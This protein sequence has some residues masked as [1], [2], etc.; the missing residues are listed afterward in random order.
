MSH[1]SVI[2]VALAATVFFA[3]STALKHRSASTL[4][5]P[6]GKHGTARLGHFLAM[7]VSHRWWLAAILADAIGLGLQAFA[8]HIGAVSVVQPVLVTALLFSLV[9]NHVAARTRITWRELGWGAFLAASVA[10]FLV[11]SGATTAGA[12]ASTADRGAAVAVAVLAV[13]LGTGSVVIA[14][15]LPSGGRAALLGVVVGTIYACTALLLK[16]VTAVAARGGLGAVLT[17]WQLPVLVLAGV[18]GMVLAQ[19]AFRSGPLNASLPAMATLDPLLSVALGVIVYDEQLRT[20]LWPTI[21]EILSLAAL[22]TGAVALSRLSADHDE[23]ASSS[24]EQPRPTGVTRGDSHGG[25][26]A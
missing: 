26:L 22:A 24:A 16:A 10:C 3:L 8:L 1:P 4:P 14:R 18:T 17:S 5:E 12:H 2:L 21:G 20:G 13:G 9:F 7:T 11:W 25:G 15:R 23:S 19:L 6:E